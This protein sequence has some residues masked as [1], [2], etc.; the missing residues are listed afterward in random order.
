MRPGGQGR[1]LHCCV[2]FATARVWRTRRSP[3][4]RIS[5]PF[6]RIEDVVV[7]KHDPADAWSRL[8]GLP[9]GLRQAL[10][11]EPASAP[12]PEALNS[13]G[14]TA[15]DNKDYAEGDAPLP[16]GSRHGRRRGDEPHRPARIRTAGALLQITARPMRWFSSGGREG[17]CR[18]DGQHRLVLPERLGVAPDSTARRCAGI[19][20]R[21]SGAVRRR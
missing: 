7:E 18:G 9:G 4:G 5:L 13:Q 15:R 2:H 14:N 19:A 3:A 20:R 6:T 17:Q 11:Y 16:P 12:T 10:N 21:P 1:N 8:A